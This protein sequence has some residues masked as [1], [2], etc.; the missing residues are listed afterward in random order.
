MSPM[1]VRDHRPEPVVALLPSEAVDIIAHFLPLVYDFAGHPDDEEP[2]MVRN[3]RKAQQIIAA[4]A[5]SGYS[6]VSEGDEDTV[7]VPREAVERLLRER[8]ALLAE[9]DWLQSELI[10][11]DTNI[12]SLMQRALEGDP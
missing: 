2:P 10:D 5:T 4:L 8:D 9:D 11:V 6:L 3:T 7:R 12:A 1:N